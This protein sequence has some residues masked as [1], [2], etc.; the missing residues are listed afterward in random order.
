MFVFSRVFKSRKMWCMQELPL[1]TDKN[2]ILFK[3]CQ[4]SRTHRSK[5]GGREI[6]A[7]VQIICVMIYAYMHIMSQESHTD[8]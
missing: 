7:L 4:L 6:T 8:I 2:V 3:S 5:N 1:D